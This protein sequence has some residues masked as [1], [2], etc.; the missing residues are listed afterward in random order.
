MQGATG[1]GTKE[2]HKSINLRNV[3]GT[4]KNG[5][6]L[7][8]CIHYLLCPVDPD[9]SSFFIFSISLLGNST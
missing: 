8:C 4:Q 5:I 7:V 2:T 3:N 6:C 1:D 9:I